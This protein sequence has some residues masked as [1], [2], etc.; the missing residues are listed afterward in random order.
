MNKKWKA[1]WK[2]HVKVTC[3][4]YKDMY[5]NKGMI[6]IWQNKGEAL[7]HEYTYAN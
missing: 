2:C 6:A 1:M 5:E 7:Y 4:R 3:K